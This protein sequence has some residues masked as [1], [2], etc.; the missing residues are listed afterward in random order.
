MLEGDIRRLRNQMNHEY[1][2]DSVVL[3]NALD[4]AHARVPMLLTTC[5]ALLA[6]MGWRGW[7]ADATPSEHA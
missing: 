2:E 7:L 5:A 3:A 6:E 1:I 4:S